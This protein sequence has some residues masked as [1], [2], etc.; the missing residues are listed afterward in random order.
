MSSSR[1]NLEKCRIPLEEI[2]QAT[3]DFSEETQVGD[4]G[5][6]MVYKGKLSENNRLVAIK[7]LNPSS[8]QGNVEFKNEVKMVSNFNH[9]NIIPFIGYCEE[10]NEQIVVY[11]Y[12]TN[13]SLDHHL[14][15]P[16]KRRCLTWVQRLKICLGA[17]RGIKYLHSGVDEHRR[18]IHRDVKS[19]NILLDDNMESKICDFGLSRLSPINQPDTHVRT[20]AAGTR[21]YMDPVYN[22]RGMLSKESDIYSFGVVMFEISSG[23]MAYHARRF[24]ETKDQKFL[25][26]IVRSYYDDNEQQLVGG[27]D[28]L[29]DPDIK[30]HICMSSFHK[31]NEIAHECINFDIK[32]RPKLDR[33]IKAIEEALHIEESWKNV[34]MLGPKDLYLSWQQNTE[35]WELGHIPQSRFPE[36]W[37]L[38]KVWWLSINGIIAAVK[39][40]EKST[41]FAY[42]VFKTTENCLGLDVPGNSSIISFGG[43]EMETENVYLQRPNSTK[44]WQENSVFP[45][46]RMDGWM[47]IKLGEFEF[48]EGDDGEV[49]ISFKEF[50]SEKTGL[51]VE[52][53]EIRTK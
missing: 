21:F 2:I 49:L 32:K 1:V 48:K 7:R 38:K 33:I 9:P 50:K 19:A 53:I 46:R 16:N 30:E 44:T 24:E 14:Q 47:E 40:S 8:R 26:D 23:M 12:A 15:D 27:L 31:F 18:V 3:N 42:L 34:Y 43:I 41:Y 13:I 45:H 17:A 22:E 35:Y 20:R 36:V 10:A 28:K 29:I 52:G 37:I 11:E 5:F 39:L 51:I 6:G 4:G 25:I